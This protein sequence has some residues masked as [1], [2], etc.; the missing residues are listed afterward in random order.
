M[1]PGATSGE[2]DQAGSTQWPSQP[3]RNNAHSSLPCGQH[4]I[5]H[6]M[7]RQV[8]STDPNTLHRQV[9][10]HRRPAITRR[11]FQGI[12]SIFQR[13]GA[14]PP[15]YPMGEGVCYHPGIQNLDEETT[16]DEDTPQPSL[17]RGDENLWIILT[18]PRS[19]WTETIPVTTSGLFL[20][21]LKIPNLN[22]LA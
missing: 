9:K 2:P 19:H 16:T 20:N 18:G 17:S 1:P 10:T 3:S 8:N 11:L 15:T 6:I 12:R 13:H 22:T 7:K 14:K 5:N 4:L 21:P